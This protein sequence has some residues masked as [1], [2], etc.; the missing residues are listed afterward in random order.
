MNRGYR[1]RLRQHQ[2]VVVAPTR[3]FVIGKAF[4]AKIFLAELVSLDERTHRAIE[5]KNALGQS[6]AELV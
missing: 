3:Q 5:N 1:A 2:N 6:V 4:A